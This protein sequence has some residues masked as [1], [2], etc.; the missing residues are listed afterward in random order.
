MEATQES[1][2][3]YVMQSLPSGT[4]LQLTNSAG[5]GIN[6]LAPGGAGTAQQLQAVQQQQ[7]QQQQQQ[8]LQQQQQPMGQGN[9]LVIATKSAPQAIHQPVQVQVQQQQP[10]LQQQHQQ[11]TITSAT[12]VAV[13]ST[14][15]GH[16]QQQQQQQVQIQQNQQNQQIP[17]Q[18][19]VQQQQ[20]QQHHPQ[21][22]QT[23][24]PIQNGQI[25]QIPVS[26]GTGAGGTI[27][28]ISGGQGLEALATVA[29][30][31][32][33]Q[34]Q[35][36][37]HQQHHQQIIAL[38]AVMGPNGT[39]M[40]INAPAGATLGASL[41]EALQGGTLTLANIGQPQ[42][43]QHHQQQQTIQLATTNTGGNS[44]QQQQQQ[45][46]NIV[47]ISSAGT[48]TIVQQQQQ[49]PQQ[50]QVQQVQVQQQQQQQPN[51]SNIGQQTIAS[52]ISAGSA[53]LQSLQG[54]QTVQTIQTVQQQQ[55]QQQ[56]QQQQ[57]QQN[58]V[59]ISQA[60][61]TNNNQQQA[62]TIVISTNSLGNLLTTPVTV[63]GQTPGLDLLACDECG[64]HFVSVAKLKSH[65]KTHS[66]SR[67][68][69]CIDCNKSFTGKKKRRNGI[70]VQR[71][72]III[73]IFSPLLADLPHANAHP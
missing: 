13:K 3:V 25:I 20:Q 37:Q 52:L 38:P 1:C 9:Y 61:Q 10:Q 60:N 35:Q 16:Q 51:S 47:T 29:G 42:P 36:Q 56:Q 46:S 64:K 39:L 66:K 34:H 18:Q 11:L 53:N 43:Q 33:Q 40:L 12:P 7:P 31:T 55:P 71:L 41:Q 28:L 2:P 62:N 48:Q 58:T 24:H 67:P 21:T 27:K 14:D 6:I 26:M 30:A 17:Q 73:F 32:L 54:L 59:T 44:G 49:Q 68:F 57:Q 15:A 65:E 72:I 22:I 70:F 8:Q 5:G 19:I 45:N 4:Q 23:F 50:I 63:T 69:K